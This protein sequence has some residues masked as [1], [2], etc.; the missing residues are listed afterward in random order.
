MSRTRAFDVD[1]ARTL[2]MRVFWR[3][4]YA[5]TSVGDLVE[6]TGVARSGLYGVFESKW[7][8]FLASLVDYRER[9]VGGLTAP[10]RDG[11]G[12]ATE[13]FLRQ[14]IT[15]ADAEALSCLLINALIEFGDDEADV[16][17]VTDA[18]LTRI[19]SGLRRTLSAEGHDA[20]AARE[21]AAVLTCLVVGA[22]VLRRSARGRRI[23]GPAI[24]A[25]L[26]LL[27]A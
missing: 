8:L 14:C 12:A 4:G 16:R 18:Y 19:E 21:I 26:K 5:A 17:E 27:G 20:K 23:S 9:V 13:R 24:R 6:A 7:G 1:R 22:F 3:Q 10:L 11:R 15:G 2:A 25:A